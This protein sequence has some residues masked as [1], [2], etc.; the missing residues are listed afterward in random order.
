MSLKT[1]VLKYGVCEVTQEYKGNAH[2]GI[3][4][5]KQGYQL[6]DIIAHSN[7]VVVQVINNCK[8]NTPT[9]KNNAGNMS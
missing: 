5:V 1:R 2:N 4:I 3:D 7:G 6:D 9:D 8:V